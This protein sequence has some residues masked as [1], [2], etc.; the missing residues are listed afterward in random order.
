MMT[1][2]LIALLLIGVV[3]LAAAGLGHLHSRFAAAKGGGG[4]SEGSSAWMHADSGS[5]GDC[6]GDGG[7]CD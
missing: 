1:P 2:L 3:A 6:G 7:G 4:G 5:V